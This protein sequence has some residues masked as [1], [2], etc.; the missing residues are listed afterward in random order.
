MTDSHP[1]PEKPAIPG[2]VKLARAQDEF[3]RTT[4]K[5]GKDLA[6]ATARLV[7]L[8]GAIEFQQAETQLKA[9]ELKALEAESRAVAAE[10][11]LLKSE[12][13][14]AETSLRRVTI[15]TRKETGEV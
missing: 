9:A 6:K 5:L 3:R 12:L 8:A 1:Y 10:V 4:D 11:R 13:R 14:I 15:E 2:L 7:Q